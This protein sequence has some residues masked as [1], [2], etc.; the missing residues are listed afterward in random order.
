MGYTGFVVVVKPL[1]FSFVGLEEELDGLMDEAVASRTAMTY[2]KCFNSFNSFCSSLQLPLQGKDSA[3]SVELWVADLSRR[4]LCYGSVQSHL[5]A[6]RHVARRNGLNIESCSDKI[7]IA[8]KGLKR[9]TKSGP[10]K[11]AISL[12]Q[13][14]LFHAGASLLPAKMCIVFKLMSSL[15]FFGFLRPSEYCV[16]SVNHHLTFGDVKISKSGTKCYLRLKS[17]KHSVRPAIIEIADSWSKSIHVVSLLKKYLDDNMQAKRSAPLFD[18]SVSKFRSMLVK[19][20]LEAGVKHVITPHCFRHGGAT[21]AS[22][23]GWSVARIQA[24]G[25]WRSQAYNSY[26][27][28]W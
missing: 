14:Q 28:S 24:H 23:Q 7:G 2:E 13:L 9:R 26:I 8:L 5:S 6:L 3:H 1:L 12:S 21:W 11:H 17:Y 4:G 22:K 27:K 15:A 16:T 18:V 10:P 19:V 25:R 20:T